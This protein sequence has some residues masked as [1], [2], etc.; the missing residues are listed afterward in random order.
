MGTIRALN[1][2]HTLRPSAEPIYYPSKE[3][4]VPVTAM[5]LLQLSYQPTMSAEILQTYLETILPL[6]T[7]LK[8][9]SGIERLP[10]NS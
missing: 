2:L 4:A 7:P 9:I 10:V 6:L 5:L 8:I 1:S 3:Y